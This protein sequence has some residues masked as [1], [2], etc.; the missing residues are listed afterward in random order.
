MRGNKEVL[1]VSYLNNPIYMVLPT[2]I[3]SKYECMYVCGINVKITNV[4][5]EFLGIEIG[6]FF[7]YSYG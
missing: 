2:L 5:I 3:Y 7:K 1:Y 4:L 6:Q